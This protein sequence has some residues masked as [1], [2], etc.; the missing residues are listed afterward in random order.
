MLKQFNYKIYINDNKKTQFMNYDWIKE[1]Y[2]IKLSDYT[3]AYEGIIED[4][5]SKDE[6]IDFVLY[7]LEDIYIRFNSNHPSGYKNRSLSI[8][9]IVMIDDRYFIVDSFGFK[10]L[11]GL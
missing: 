4:E 2:A 8:S 10:E 1:N 6:S 5:V 11:V 9:D 3:K 7:L